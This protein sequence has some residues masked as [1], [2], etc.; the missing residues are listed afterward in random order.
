MPASAAIAIPDTVKVIT[1]SNHW[2]SLRVGL[3][4]K[5][6][7]GDRFSLNLDAAWLPYVKLN[8]ADTHWLRIGTYPGAFTG[9]VPEDGTGH[10]LSARGRRSPTRSIRMSASRSA[11]AT[12]AWNS[13]GHTHFEDHVVGVTAYPQPVDW[14]VE[15]LGVFVQG[16]FKF[17]PYPTGGVF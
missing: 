13:N 14:K 12:G 16:S 15:N 7:L 11:A 9:A 17:G 1:Q 5:I 3:D 6:A 10:R 4:A 8:G 2:N